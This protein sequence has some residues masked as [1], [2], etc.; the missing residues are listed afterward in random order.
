MV[1]LIY[2]ASQCWHIW[3]LSSTPNALGS[4]AFASAYVANTYVRPLCGPAANRYVDSRLC[5]RSLQVTALKRTPANSTKSA[6]QRRNCVNTQKEISGYVPFRATPGHYF[7]RL[8]FGCIV[9]MSIQ[10]DIALDVIIMLSNKIYQIMC[11]LC[12]AYWSGSGYWIWRIHALF[13]HR[14]CLFP[15]ITATND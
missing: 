9:D 1:L 3:F 13:S 2:M 12:M 8:I 5:W 10:P 14:F 11:P 4:Q 15:Q 6:R 7:D